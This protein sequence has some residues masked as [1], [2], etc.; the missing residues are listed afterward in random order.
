VPKIACSFVYFCRVQIEV[1][2]SKLHR[3]T[4]TGADLHYIGSITIDQD[5]LDA[6][7]MISGEKVVVVNV[8]NGSRLETYIIPGERGSGEV[9]MNGPAARLV[10]KGDVV[11]VFSYALIEFEKAKAFKPW[12]VFPDE[13]SN[14][15]K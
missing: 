14:S 1:V 10:Q 6:A 12:V 5:L 2:K 15:L 11:I 13:D 3:V 9:T 7:H 8:N 4:I